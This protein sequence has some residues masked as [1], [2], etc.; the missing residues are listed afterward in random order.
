[1]VTTPNNPDDDR[2][3]QQLCAEWVAKNLTHPDELRAEIATELDELRAM[4]MTAIAVTDPPPPPAPPTP[5]ANP[6]APVQEP[7]TV[8]IP[9][10]SP[11]PPQA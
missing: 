9:T 10:Q 8:A 7:P 6:P 3:Y 1:M 11:P 4:S 2:M 5:P